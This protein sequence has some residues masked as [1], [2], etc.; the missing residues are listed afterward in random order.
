MKV[1]YLHGFNSDSN[2]TTIKSLKASIPDLISIS[3]DYINADI[4]YQQI[5]SLVEET[6]NTDP[7]L[8]MAGTSLGGFWANYFAQ[9]FNL[10]CVIVNPALH[11]SVSL[12][13][14]V[15]LSPIKNYNSGEERIFTYENTDA[16]K[17]YEV[18]IGSTDYFICNTSFAQMKSIIDTNQNIM[19]PVIFSGNVNKFCVPDSIA[20][21]I[22]MRYNIKLT[23]II[24]R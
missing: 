16:Y 13:K 6:L 24:K 5:N 3:Y 19:Y 18:E 20:G 11:P 21:Y 8:L 2:S 1:I 17:K 10:K 12:R 9:K 14:A 4:A 23:N 22:D 15:E 7:E